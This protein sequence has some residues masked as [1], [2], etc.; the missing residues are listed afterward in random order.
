MQ[1][2]WGPQGPLGGT[3]GPM[4]GQGFVRM[5]PN[6][7]SALPARGG[8]PPVS[9]VMANMQMMGNGAQK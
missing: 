1:Q 9:R 5:V 8:A 3:M 4:M 7:N 2:G 6:M